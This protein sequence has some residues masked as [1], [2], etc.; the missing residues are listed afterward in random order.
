M[1]DD[2]NTELVKSEDLVKLK[3]DIDVFENQ[4]QELIELVRSTK[5]ITCAGLDD[6]EGFEKVNTAYKEIRDK[7]IELEKTGKS[8]RDMIT[9]ITKHISA[10]EKELVD[11]LEPEEQR[12]KEQRDN[13]NNLKAEEKKKK[14]EAERK[15]VED[16]AKQLMAIPHVEF[17]GTTYS[18]QEITLDQQYIGQLSEEQF[19]GFISTLTKK[20][21]TITKEK[22]A[23]VET[24][25][26]ADEAETKRKNE[27]AAELKRQ[28]DKLKQEQD[29][30]KKQK[31]QLVKMRTESRTNVLLTGGWQ[32][33]GENF[34]RES[35][36]IT[37]EAV[38]NNTDSEFIEQFTDA[39]ETANKQKEAREKKESEEKEAARL[40]GIQEEKDRQILSTRK[41]L[42]KP[43]GTENLPQDRAIISMQQGAFDEYL[44]SLKKDKE[45]R[46]SETERLIQYLDELDKIPVPSLKTNLKQHVANVHNA[47]DAA[48]KSLPKK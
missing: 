37:K 3:T 38:E 32:K 12:L 18:L 25:R 8:M 35:V 19:T 15:I 46:L 26:L 20:S 43:Y 21:E 39:N 34:T 5:G 48:R 1:K 28:Q 30:L 10:K 36:V 16:R 44:L 40:K 31:E 22:E 24:K 9:P 42:L 41:E 47:I 7:R 2:K 11:V 23:E 14:E 6:K 29:E 13:Y 33:S 45:N 27:E 4:K 17:N